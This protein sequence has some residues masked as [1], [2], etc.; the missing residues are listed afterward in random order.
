M[1]G[2]DE[3]KLTKFRSHKEFTFANPETENHYNW[4]AQ[5]FRE[6]NDK[7]THQTFTY[8]MEIDGFIPKMLVEHVPGSRGGCLSENCFCIWTL[9]GCTTC[10]R[11]Y[12]AG[13]AGRK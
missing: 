2:L 4:H 5:N 3:Y 9:L 12:F 11:M 7:D 1:E 8:G 10:F 13:K 6:T